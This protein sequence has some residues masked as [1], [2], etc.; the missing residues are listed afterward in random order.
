MIWETVQVFHTAS[1]CISYKLFTFSHPRYHTWPPF[2][3]ILHKKINL[4]KSKS[5]SANFLETGSMSWCHRVMETNISHNWITNYHRVCGGMEWWHLTLSGFIC[6]RSQNECPM[7][8]LK[9]NHASLIDLVRY[10]RWVLKVRSLCRHY[11]DVIMTAMASQITG[12]TIV[13]STVYSRR[14]TREHQSS[15]SGNSPMT[16]EFPA[17]RAS[18]PENVSIWWRHGIYLNS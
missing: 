12:L 9:W 3:S 1:L 10:R 7:L 8:K 2:L 5:Q 18:N 6:C 17:Q 11:N 13:C 16:G 15:A 4:I 14:R